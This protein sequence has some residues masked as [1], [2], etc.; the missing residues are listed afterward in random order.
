MIFVILFGFYILTVVNALYFPIYIWEGWPANLTWSDTLRTLRDVN[1]SPFYFLAFS[2]R[3]FSMRWVIVDF[4]L[5]LLLTIPF[6]FGI[7]YFRKPRFLKLCLW[8]IGTGLTLEGVQLLFKLGFNNYHVVDINDVILNGL[9]VF[10][11]F[12]LFKIAKRVFTKRPK[13][14]SAA[15]E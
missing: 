4:G 12:I 13:L 9:G 5:N 14:Q 6:G 11:G 7:G 2:N 3:P 10:I 8:A 15:V 1:L